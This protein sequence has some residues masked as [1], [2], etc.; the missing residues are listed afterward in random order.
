[1]RQNVRFVRGTCGVLVAD[2]LAQA[3]DAAELIELDFDDLDIAHG[4]GGGQTHKIHPQAP[5]NVF[6]GGRWGDIAAVDAVP[7]RTAS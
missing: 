2:T 1:L 6:D 5:D 3:R 4:A 7:A